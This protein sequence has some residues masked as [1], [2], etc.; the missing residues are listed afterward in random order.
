[1]IR[2]NTG[3]RLVAVILALLLL[4][5]GAKC[6]YADSMEKD[7]DSARTET[8]PEHPQR[9]TI[10]ESGTYTLTGKMKGTVYVDPGEGEVKL[11]LDNVDIEGI[12][13]P[14]IVAVSGD[15][16]TVELTECSYNRIADSKQNT[17][18][19]AF[20]STVDTEFRGC[21]CLQ[22]E[23]NSMYGLYSEDADITFSY[24]KYL[25]L[26]E[27]EGIRM[28]GTDAGSLFLNGGCVFVNTDNDPYI[29]ADE[30]VQTAGML[31]VTD[32]TD[33]RRIDCCSAGRC[34]GCCCERKCR[35]AAADD[36]EDDDSCECRDSSV[37]RPGEIREGTVTNRAVP[38]QEEEEVCTIVF[39]GNKQHYEVT[40][41]GTYLITGTSADG[42]LSV[43]KNTEGVV[44][45]LKDLDL[46]NTSGAVLK[47]NGSAVVKIV[48]TGKVSLTYASDAG[49]SPVSHASLETGSGSEVC[50]SGEGQLTVTG[51][52]G[53]GILTGE[54]SSL[55]IDGTA[56]IRITAADDGIHAGNDAAVL[57]GTISVE[58]GDI[59]IHAD[60]VLTI[61]GKEGAEPDVQV[62]ESREGLDA[63][64]VNIEGGT[65]GIH[66]KEDGIDAEAA[67]EGTD[68][69]VNITGGEVTI[70]AGET[71]ID[72][73][74]NVNLTGGS[75]V[76]E[77]KDADGTCSCVDQ[78]GD[79][80]ISEEFVLDCGCEE[81]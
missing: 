49:N 25:F 74:G 43:A 78:E 9:L 6:V 27:N 16:L 13:E 65:I 41:P 12:D 79:L 44:L 8:D 52:T 62:N 53:D 45:V 23:G 51:K 24:G 39:D 19:A 26:T 60:D 7:T 59:G 29:K 18:K 72:S 14:A 28:D 30:I 21:G 4:P 66:A 70:Q 42:S 75:A 38:L 37:D 48:I 34:L 61:G 63:A 11:I 64:V 77:S 57:D 33:V 69:S 54:N 10:H 36:D 55:V 17:G 71:A 40:D 5:A 80:Y 32:E 47:V 3:R 15:K 31:E 81:E 20:Y 2:T 56:D 35:P 50:I 22:T 73:D 68:T 1:M 58:A 76:I 46:T 67:A